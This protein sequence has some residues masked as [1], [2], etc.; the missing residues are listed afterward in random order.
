MHH[1]FARGR[2]SAWDG[3][4]EG[5]QLLAIHPGFRGVTASPP[6][7][8]RPKLKHKDDETT[9]MPTQP[10]FR[11][12][13]LDFHT[14]EHIPTVGATFNGEEFAQT[15]SQSGVDAVVLFAKCHHGW[16]YYDTACGERHPNL[17]F[18]LLHQQVEACQAQGVQ[19]PIYLSVGWDERQ[20][21]MNPGWRQIKPDGTF[22][23]LLGD[24]LDA[25]WSYMCLNSPYLDAVCEQIEEITKVFPNA[26]G[27]WLD[28]IKQ[29]Q[30]CCNYCRASMA[31]KGLDFLKE[32]DRIQHSKDVLDTY[33][34][35]ATQAAR[36][37]NP[38]MGVFHNTS[39]AP[40]GDRR[41]FDAFS[42][43]EIEAVPTGGWG[44][45]HLPLSAK[46]LETL[47]HN[48]MGVTV[49]FHIVWG[50]LGGY[51]PLPALRYEV[52]SMLT[53]GCR[54][55]IGDQLDPGGRLDGSTY[56]IIGDVMDE[57]DRKRPFAE[58]TRNIADIAL[59]S[60][61]A[62]R[63]PGAVSRE[64]RHN[65][66]DEGA[67][68]I[69]QESHFLFDVIDA[70]ADFSAYK[71]I[72][73]PDQIRLSPALADRVQ[74][75]VAAGGKLLLTGQ[76]GFATDAPGFALP[77]H[78]AFE[79]QCPFDPTFIEPRTDVAPA[80]IADPFCV[81]TPSLMVKP[82][83]EAVSLGDVFH[84]Y[85]NRTPHHF[86]GH[87]HAPPRAE[88]SGHACGVI[89]GRVAY[90]PHFVFTLYRRLGPHVIKA[91]VANVIDHMLGDD[92][93]LTSD[94]LP[95]GAVV[96]MRRQTRHQ[97]DI[98]HL[99]YAAPRLRG[100]T[101]LGPLEAIDDTPTLAPM[102]IT[103]RPRQSVT[104]VTTWDGAA[105]A[106]ETRGANQIRFLT[107]PLTGHDLYCVNFA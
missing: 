30:C 6:D 38:N 7:A 60:S 59:L 22:F 82:T 50:E 46:Y 55:C 94:T 106:F 78:I 44:Y 58:H 39:M 56:R 33:Y 79:G 80:G 74:T 69:L 47:G 81:M 54:V 23:C 28:I 2:S 37:H 51:K 92:R 14:S 90:L 35:R 76:S 83:G 3:A 91:F 17:S 75:Y 18:D 105:V 24:N 100:Q 25:A 49:R 12:I 5:A 9:P 41:F 8:R 15:L 73:L 40:R 45:D 96:T 101:P 104:S 86:N 26:D 88:P 99:L 53:H 65:V 11:Q 70:E 27:L 72:V 43:V 107:R 103:I 1:S 89:D 93:T 52:M 10:P 42:H 87:I 71:L 77:L 4:N 34:A 68:K 21:R 85:F 36:K 95:S 61:I 13:H 97:R 32:A 31:E 63:E 98:V 57:V 102:D 84:P 48:P 64:A 16:S 62:V 66:E 67:L 19:T 29:D 20:A